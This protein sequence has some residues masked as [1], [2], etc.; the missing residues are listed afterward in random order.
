[1]RDQNS[2]IVHDE[3]VVNK[4][5]GPTAVQTRRKDT[6]GELHRQRRSGKTCRHNVGP[7][8]RQ[9]LFISF[10]IKRDPYE[11]PYLGSL[12]T[13]RVA[14]APLSLSLASL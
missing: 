14:F 9:L 1:M 11:R 2:S 4:K 6:R 7:T 13:P 3:I 5:F 10:I 8:T 12:G